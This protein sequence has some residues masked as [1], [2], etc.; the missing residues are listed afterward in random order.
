MKIGI[1]LA[2]LLI[3]LGAIRLGF[4]SKG[5]SDSE[6]IRTAMNDAVV[7][8][9]EG[10]AGPVLDFLSDQVTLNDMMTPTKTQIA[11]YI[12]QNKPEVVVKAEEPVVSGD[13]ASMV[14][15]VHVVVPVP[16]GSAYSQNFKNVT[17][18]FKREAGVQWLILPAKAWRLTKVTT[19]EMPPLDG[20]N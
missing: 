7:A 12:R 20:T 15:E 18:L 8:A 16:G 10:R 3:A 2:V 1:G 11:N 13:S 4:F 6:L 9:K 5:P 14:T 17:L 19:Q